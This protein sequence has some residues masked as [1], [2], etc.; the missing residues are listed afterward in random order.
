MNYNFIVFSTLLFFVDV[1]F[2]MSNHSKHR[3]GIKIIQRVVDM[4]EDFHMD[5]SPLYVHGS[6]FCLW[7]FEPARVKPI[8]LSH[9]LISRPSEYGATCNLCI[10]Q[11]VAR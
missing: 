8:K 11:S 6:S 4:E 7:H 3:F 9:N 2:V 10:Y 1:M 5:Q